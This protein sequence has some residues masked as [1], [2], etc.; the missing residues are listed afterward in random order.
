MT[1]AGGAV[2]ATAWVERRKDDLAMVIEC[3]GTRLTN[4]P[5]WRRVSVEREARI[6]EV[7]RGPEYTLGLGETRTSAEWLAKWHQL[8]KD[9]KD[10]VLR[11]SDDNSS[12]TMSSAVRRGARRFGGPHME[13]VMRTHGFYVWTLYQEGSDFAQEL[14]AWCLGLFADYEP[15]PLQ[16]MKKQSYLPVSRSQAEADEFDM[17]LMDE[18]GARLQDELLRRVELE[19]GYGLDLLSSYHVIVGDPGA[20]IGCAHGDHWGP[21]ALA[22]TVSVGAG[23]AV[24]TAVVQVDDVFYGD[25]DDEA[26]R[27][28][29]APYKWASY[30]EVKRARW[31]AAR[32]AGIAGLLPSASIYCPKGDGRFRLARN[33][34]KM[35]VSP[36]RWDE[37]YRPRLNSGRP[38]LPQ[39]D[40][41]AFDSTSPHLFPGVAEREAQRL[42]LYL[43][44]STPV[45]KGGTVGAGPV[46]WGNAEADEPEGEVRTAFDAAGEYRMQSKASASRTKDGKRARVSEAGA[47]ASLAQLRRGGP[48][49]S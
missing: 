36:T 44:F 45:M 2:S 15:E 21:P 4:V 7:F 20:H 3:D 17:V 31:E 40:A 28:G 37:P 24:S 43:G 27:E 29:R 8:R 38:R 11:G 34:E 10:K 1:T 25:S 32:A 47:A 42:T 6:M 16:G 18:V 9:F 46:G 19:T 23:G 41:M 48:G 30:E 14:E 49:R 13:P 22:L 12:R 5:P 26:P 39:G 35:F 33:K